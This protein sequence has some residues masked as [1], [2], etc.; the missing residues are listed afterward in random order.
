MAQ[1]RFW[2]EGEKIFRRTVILKEMVGE[3]AMHEAPCPLLDNQLVALD[4]LCA[5]LQSHIC[6]LREIV[7]KEIEL[8]NKG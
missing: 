5:K 1:Q 3:Q 7:K 2:G 6:K 4:V 8:N